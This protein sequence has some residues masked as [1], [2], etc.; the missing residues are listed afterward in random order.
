L[1]CERKV[2]FHL[3]RPSE[4]DT[5]AWKEIGW[6]GQLGEALHDYFVKR[7]AEALKEL[8][9]ETEMEVEVHK[10]L[11]EV[12]WDARID[13]IARKDGK[14]IVYDFKFVSPSVVYT[15]NF[16]VHQRQIAIYASLVDAHAA[17]LVYVDRTNPTRIN[18]IVFD[19]QDLIKIQTEAWSFV[20]FVKSLLRNPD[21]L[22]KVQ[23]P[24]SPNA[25][26]CK[27]TS[28]EGVAHCPFYRLCHGNTPVS[29]TLLDIAGD[30]NIANQLHQLITNYIEITNAINE[31][32]AELTPLQKQRDML[33][34]QLIEL[35]PADK[36]VNTKYGT[37]VVKQIEQ[38]RL[39]TQAAKDIFKSLGVEPP[40]K[41]VLSHQIVVSLGG[42][43]K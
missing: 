13:L 3:T 32:E 18:H 35:L 16:P 23:P 28:K 20:R 36:P 38:K 31:V 6:L 33:K 37:L 40:I 4:G 27:F 25:Y 1:S 29:D 22:D 24:Y 17:V 9:Y 42:E 10:E 8:G 12:P 7:Y 26:P 41:V 11:G 30:P 2:V 15:A 21:M 5:L 39:D 34:S 19:D 14:T 43:N